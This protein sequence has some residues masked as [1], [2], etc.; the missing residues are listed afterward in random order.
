MIRWSCSSST[1]RSSRPL[2]RGQAR[3]SMISLLIVSAP[4]VWRSAPEA[5]LEE[6]AE[7]VGEEEDD[8]AEDD[9]SGGV[10]DGGEPAAGWGLWVFGAA[11]GEE[12]D[13]VEHAEGEEDFDG[14]DGD[15]GYA[16]EAGGDAVEGEDG[17]GDE[18]DAEGGVDEGEVVAAR[19]GCVVWGT[20]E[21]GAED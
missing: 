6:G 16:D 18:E 15:V 21:A 2:H 4:S 12:S 11:V 14:E 19:V 10:G 9:Y 5:L 17:A 3:M 13:E 8:D 7:D 20:S 1:V